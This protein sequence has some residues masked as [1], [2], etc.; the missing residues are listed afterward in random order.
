[1]IPS[2]YLIKALNHPGSI[3]TIL[4]NNARNLTACDLVAVE[5]AAQEKD[6]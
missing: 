2:Q 1:M 3:Q 4:S 6:V 5:R